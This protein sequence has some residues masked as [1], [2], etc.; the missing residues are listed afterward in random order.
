MFRANP[1]RYRL[2]HVKDVTGLG[3]S[4]TS[5]VPVGE[6]EIDYR[7]VFAAA[8]I[9]GLEHFFIEQDNAPQSD[10]MDAIATSARNLRNIL[11]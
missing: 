11:R 9:A 1:G 2:W 6:G 4:A 7:A 8:Q 5:F 10:S 3:T